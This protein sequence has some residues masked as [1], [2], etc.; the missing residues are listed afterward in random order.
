[1]PRLC[2][3]RVVLVSILVRSSSQPHSATSRKEL[4]YDAASSLA[5]RI[6]K[7]FGS[8]DSQSAFR[9]VGNRVDVGYSFHPS[10]SNAIALPVALAVGVD[11]TTSDVFSF[12]DQEPSAVRRG[13]AAKRAESI[14]ANATNTSTTNTSTS[15]SST[16]SESRT[17]TFST[18]ISSSSTSVT[19][20]FS[21]LTSTN[22][23]AT[24]TSTSTSTRTHTSSTA[25][26][27]TTT[28]NTTS[29]STTSSTTFTQTYSSTTVT[30][31]TLTSTTTLTTFIT[32]TT[33]S[34]GTNTSL[35][36]SST[37]TRSS[38]STTSVTATL[39]VVTHTV[40]STTMSTTTTRTHTHYA[41]LMNYLE[42]QPMFQQMNSMK[43]VTSSLANRRMHQSAQ[44]TIVF[45]ILINCRPAHC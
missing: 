35:S 12:P 38:L 43:N 4:R 15:S 36:T 22:T 6:S 20:T 45:L 30:E 8:R 41:W 18:T 32:N 42:T 28:S 7:T 33:T 29:A 23:T 5:S 13:L 34:T 31:T 27:T 11:P 24:N 17:T 39:T 1:M 40:T 9:R 14:F 26:S 19:S 3:V 21:T 16:L 25:V 37:T 44:I 2:F 10:Q